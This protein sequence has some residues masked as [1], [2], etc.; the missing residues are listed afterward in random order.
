MEDYPTEIIWNRFDP[1]CFACS[2]RVPRFVLACK[3][4]PDGN[5]VALTRPGATLETIDT[6]LSYASD[7]STLSFLNGGVV[8]EPI[9][10]RG[11]MLHIRSA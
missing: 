6:D 11:V 8:T 4:S 7:G 10:R 5:R 2:V 9:P 1:A 3:M